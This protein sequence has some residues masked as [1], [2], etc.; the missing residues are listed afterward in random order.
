MRTPLKPG[1]S[2]D[3]WDRLVS[4]STRYFVAY[5]RRCLHQVVSQSLHF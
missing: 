5:S 1:S 4:P 2:S 3:R